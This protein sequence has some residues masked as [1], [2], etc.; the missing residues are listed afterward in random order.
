MKK[1][2]FILAAIVVMTSLY[3][4][5]AYCQ[6]LSS[7]EISLDE[8]SWMRDVGFP[9]SKYSFDNRNINDE[10]RLG[11]MEQKKGKK[12]NKIA[13]IG[14]CV[15]IATMIVGGTSA[16]SLTP[17]IAGGIISIGGSVTSF[18]AFSKKQKARKRIQN[19]AYL[20]DDLENQ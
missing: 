5:K 2:K 15:G 6:A 20:Y 19:A 9:I 13:W 18:I 16:K 1:M 14:V 4:Q 10:L 11:L 12:L 3:A 8:K 17:Q 7:Q